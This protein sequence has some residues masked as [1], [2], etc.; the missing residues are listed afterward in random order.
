MIS[1][2]AAARSHQGQTS[3]RVRSGIAELAPD[4]IFAR[5]H[6]FWMLVHLGVGCMALRGQVADPGD[7]FGEFLV[8]AWRHLLAPSVADSGWFAG[9]QGPRSSGAGV[10]GVVRRRRRWPGGRDRPSPA[11]IPSGRPWSGRG[12]VLAA[13]SDRAG[14]GSW[15]L[16][17][18][19]G[20][21]VAVAGLAGRLGFGVGAGGA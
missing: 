9:A 4:W 20:G 5:H 7:P 1:G 21:A 15:R 19:A 2:L 13:G 10:D 11:P 12:S 17:A 8:P 3:E 14:R 18:R 16:G 6:P